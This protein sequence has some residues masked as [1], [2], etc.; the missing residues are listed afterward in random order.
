MSMTYGMHMV[1][2]EDW[3][4]V[5]VFIDGQYMGRLV[6]NTHTG[7]WEIELKFPDGRIIHRTM[8]YPSDEREAKAYFGTMY[9]QGKL[10]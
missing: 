3:E 4:G 5:D 9:S 2:S 6:Q 7:I 8:P 10:V 1:Y